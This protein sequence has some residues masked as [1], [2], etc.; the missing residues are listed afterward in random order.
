MHLLSTNLLFSNVWHFRHSSDQS[1]TIFSSIQP[2]AAMQPNNLCLVCFFILTTMKSAVQILLVR[3]YIQSSATGT[4]ALFQGCHGFDPSGW[5]PSAD[6]RRNVVMSTI[7]VVCFLSPCPTE[8]NNPEQPALFLETGHNTLQTPMPL[9][10]V[11]M[12]HRMFGTTDLT[13]VR[14]TIR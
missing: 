10:K 9:Y 2:I 11:S 14:P 3:H 13:V 7:H 8:P 12:P 5:C 1:P 4:I 6:A